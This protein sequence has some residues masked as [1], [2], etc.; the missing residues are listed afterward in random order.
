MPE[1]GRLR[2]GTEGGHVLGAHG[3]RRGHGLRVRE[4][5]GARSELSWVRAVLD[6]SRT[7]ALPVEATCREHCRRRP[8]P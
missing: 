3:D 1:T 5:R 7:F 8:N 6:R 4:P 2:A